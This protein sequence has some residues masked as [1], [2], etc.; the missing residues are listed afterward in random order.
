[1]NS[2]LAKIDDLPSK[3][4]H[5]YDD[6]I[7]YSADH[8]RRRT[9]DR[10]YEVREGLANLQLSKVELDDRLSS[11]GCHGNGGRGCDYAS[12]LN[13][14]EGGVGENVRKVMEGLL[15]TEVRL[16]MGGAERKWDDP[17]LS[18][19]MRHEGVKER[20]R[21]RDHA[22]KMALRERQQE[23]VVRHGAKL[24]VL[25]ERRE[26]RAREQREEAAI[27]DHMAAIKRQ[28]KQQRERER[29]GYSFHFIIILFCSVI[30]HV[31]D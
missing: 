19:E 8:H 20:R 16:P 11:L 21:L 17:L 25:R 27:R 24:L 10:K 14:G 1:M 26:E 2:W 15:D 30:L 22:Q 9:L 6:P 18:M 29:Y 12:E 13:W 23:D 7:T 28:M 4:S 31:C 3:P 5:P